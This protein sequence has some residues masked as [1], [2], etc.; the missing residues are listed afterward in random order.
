M[1][2]CAPMRR[3]RKV[4]MTAIGIGLGLMLALALGFAAEAAARSCVQP[5]LESFPVIVHAQVVR[6]LARERMRLHVVQALRGDA[7]GAVMIVDYRDVMVWTETDPFAAG[8]EWVLALDAA[9]R[10]WRLSLCA[11]EYAPVEA[12]RVSAYLDD[13]GYETLTIDELA[14]RLA[15]P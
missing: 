4:R 13:A 8:S 14:A 3:D 10:G 7:T 2:A 11:S 1:L 15:R 12:G 9:A 6:S 5:P